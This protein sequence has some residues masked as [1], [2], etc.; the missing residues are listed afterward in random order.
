VGADSAPR[1]LDF[2]SVDCLTFA[3]LIKRAD[4]ARTLFVGVPDCLS[5]DRLRRRVTL[6]TRHVTGIYAA[7]SDRQA[8]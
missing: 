4:R 7:D 8:A 2:S 3:D 6:K 1:A 5:T